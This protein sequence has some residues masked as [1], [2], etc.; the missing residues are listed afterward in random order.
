MTKR[1]GDELGNPLGMRDRAR[2]LRDRTQ[3]AHLIDRLQWKSVVIGKRT[4][5]ANQHHR[6]RIHEGIGDAGDRIG[7]ARTGGDDRDAG[8]AGGARPSVGHMRGG[9]L[10]TRVDDAEVVPCGGRINRIEMPAVESED[11]MHALALE[12]AHHHFAAVDFRHRQYLP[13][14]RR[15]SSRSLCEDCTAVLT[16]TPKRREKAIRPWVCEGES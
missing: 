5:T 14:A 4:A 6:N 3:D 13:R 7:H 8:A 12:R 1:R 10:V 9:L 15:K 11:F 2:P 16:E